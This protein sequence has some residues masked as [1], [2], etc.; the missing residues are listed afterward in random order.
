MHPRLLLKVST[1][2]K[3]LLEQAD[4]SAFACRMK[5]SGALEIMPGHLPLIGATQAGTVEYLVGEDV[6]ELKLDA[7]ILQVDGD[8]INL[9]V[10]EA[11][12]ESST[13]VEVIHGRL[14]EGLLKQLKAA[15]KECEAAC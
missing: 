5:G 10:M 14:E 11:G 13:K 8:T 7:G 12:F 1:P 9:L 15:V 3:V 6:H 4:V 2:T